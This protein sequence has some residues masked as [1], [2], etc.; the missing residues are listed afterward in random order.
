MENTTHTQMRT[1]THDC[2]PT[3][4]II[5]DLMDVPGTHQSTHEMQNPTQLTYG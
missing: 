2:H 3:Q 4:P 5:G 1:H